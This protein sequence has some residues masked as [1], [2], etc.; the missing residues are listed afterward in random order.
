MKYITGS[1]RNTNVPKI[2]Q[3]FLIDGR[4]VSVDVVGSP[5]HSSYVKKS[6]FYSGM[7]FLPATKQDFLL[8]W[9]GN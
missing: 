3:K 1:K 2:Y 8:F 7:R 4:V 9:G 5:S 6:R